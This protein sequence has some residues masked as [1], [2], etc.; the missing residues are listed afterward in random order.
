MT[1]APCSRALTLAAVVALAALLAVPSASPSDSTDYVIEANVQ[2]VAGE[3]G[4]YVCTTTIH[5]AAAH[6]VLASPKLHFRRGGSVGRARL[7][8]V[9]QP[10][11]ILELSVA[12]TDTGDARYEARLLRPGVAQ[13]VTRV[14]FALTPR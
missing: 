11:M 14:T 3:D 6:Q 5:D 8:D 1:R 4:A 10:G 2:P 7:A 12:I 13:L 9:P